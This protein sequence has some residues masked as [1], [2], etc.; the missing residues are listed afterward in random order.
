[1][2]QL[3]HPSMTTRKTIALTLLAMS[4]LFNML[5]RF[6]IAFLTMSKHF[7]FLAIVTI[8]NDFGAQENKI[9][10][11]FHCFPIYLPS[12]DG[13]GCHDFSI[14]FFFECWV[15]R[16]FFILLFHLHQ[17]TL[18]FLLV[19]LLALCHKGC[20]I[21]VS[22]V[23]SFSQQSWFQLVLHSAWH[24]TRCTLHVS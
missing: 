7:N 18:Y 20:V 6:A 15:L 11:C 4:L 10:H 12:S 21:C 13:S 1:M 23:I 2:V 19:F 5:S 24:S 22:E 14:F 17:E 9:C 8:C 16:N 3:S